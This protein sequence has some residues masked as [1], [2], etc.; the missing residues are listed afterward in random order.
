MCARRRLPLDTRPPV[1]L[2]EN[3][4]RRRRQ[5]DSVTDGEQA[6]YEHTH[7][8]IRLKA[9]KNDEQREK[10]EY[11][12]VCVRMAHTLSYTR[13]SVCFQGRR[14]AGQLRTIN[15]TYLEAVHRLPSLFLRNA[16]I[17]DDD[18]VFTQSSDQVVDYIAMMRKHDQF[19]IAAPLDGDVVVVVAIDVVVVVVFVVDV[20]VVDVVVVDVAISIVAF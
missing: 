7:V 17:D 18:T 20:V 4:L 12:S 10:R 14:R 1:N 5:R 19:A 3:D 2:C 15:A 11:V 13:P 6:T 16:T 9:R 8:R